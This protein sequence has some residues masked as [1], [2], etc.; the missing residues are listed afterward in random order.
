MFDFLNTILGFYANCGMAWVVVVASDIVIN[1][2]LLKISPTAP[3]VPPR[4]ALRDQPG[5]LRLH[6]HLGRGLDRRVLRRVGPG[7]QPFSPLVAIVLALV[8]PPVLALATRGRYYLR[9]T[10]DGIDSPM[11]D[12]YGNP[13][14]EVMQCHVCREGIERPDLV[15]ARPTTRWCARCA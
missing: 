6:D 3:G 7:T 11:F 5:R 15:A 4:H 1:K 13:S 14:G 9:R 10:D 8:L 12:E 2:Y